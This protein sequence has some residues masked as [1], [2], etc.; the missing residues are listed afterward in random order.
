MSSAAGTVTK[1]LREWR[2]GD[3]AAFDALMPVVYAELQRLAAAHL[4]R[5]RAGHTLRPGDLVAEAYLRLS[6]SEYRD[7]EDRRHFFSIAAR[8]MRQLLID[9]ARKHNAAK[10]GDGARAI[11]FDEAL[12]AGE[13]PEELAALDDALRALGDYDE[14]KAQIVDLHYFAGLTQPEIASLI[15]LHVNTVARDLRFA[16]AWIQRYLQAADDV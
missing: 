5:E 3:A 8:T 16:E 15:G 6:E 13:R 12:I 1:L 4:R 2:D 14:R 11:T 10:R 7:L 9:H